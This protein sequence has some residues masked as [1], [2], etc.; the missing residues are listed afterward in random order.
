MDWISSAICLTVRGSISK[1][2]LERNASPLN[3][4]IIRLYFTDCVIFSPEN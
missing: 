2:L 3:F 1:L 4:K